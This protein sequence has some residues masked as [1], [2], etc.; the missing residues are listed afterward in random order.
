[1]VTRAFFV[2]IA[3]VSA[4]AGVH[5]AHQHKFSGVGDLSGCACDGNYAILERLTQRFRGSLRELGELVEEEY[6]VV[7]HGYLSRARI[8]SAAY[9]SRQTYRMMRGAEGTVCDEALAE[10]SAYRMYLRGF[11]RLLKVHIGEY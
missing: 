7:S 5:S 8:C 4:T 10:L 2:R 1:M 3:E 9:E 6:T 11:E